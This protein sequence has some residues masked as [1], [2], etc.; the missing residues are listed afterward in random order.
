MTEKGVGES[1]LSNPFGYFIL[2]GEIL[3]DTTS[4]N[5]N[6]FMKQL[7][8]LSIY[9]SPDELYDSN[10]INNNWQFDINV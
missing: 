9:V 10:G 6:A 5:K 8:I 3:E 1:K 2:P 7:V 4:R